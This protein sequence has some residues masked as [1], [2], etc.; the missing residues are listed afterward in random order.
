MTKKKRYKQKKSLKNK[1][2]N[3]KGWFFNRRYPHSRL[4]VGDFTLNMGLVVILALT[5]FIVLSYFGDINGLGVLFTGLGIVFVVVLLYFIARYLYKALI[6]LKQGIMG[7]TNGVK[8]ILVII[9]ILSL[10]E[11]YQINPIINTFESDKIITSFVNHTSI[12]TVESNFI[13][14]TTN[15]TLVST[16]TPTPT[17]VKVFPTSTPTPT[18]TPTLAPERKADCKEAFDYVNTIRINNG[19]NKLK[20]D[21]R[22][23]ELAVDRSKDM[24][25]RNYFDHVTPEGTCANEMK[26]KYGFEFY[27][28]LAEN[29]GGM[30]H[31]FNGEPIPGENVQNT[32]DSW[33]NSRGHRYN[34]LY[35]DHVGGAI[36]CYKWICVFYGVHNNP[37]GLGAGPCKTGEE[38]LAFWEQASKQP[39]EIE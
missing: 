31:Y 11:V 2:Y 6:N 23:Y 4:R 8:L 29:C 36:G 13:E 1:Y 3:F 25:E 33:M 12:E 30:T 22:A 14:N 34:L 35:E 9:L 28:I 20:W 5:L 7:L 37:N 38:G 17:Q 27:E 19:R 39:G 26:G 18:P 32:V 21:D 16:S 15:D 24:F 10:W